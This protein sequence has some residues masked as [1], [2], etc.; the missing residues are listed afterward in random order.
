MCLPVTL[1]HLQTTVQFVYIRSSKTVPVNLT[2]KP[3][4][5]QPNSL[6][7]LLLHHVNFFNSMDSHYTFLPGPVYRE[8]QD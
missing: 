1:L 4:F 3:V 2:M 7:S 5:Q 8:R 6:G